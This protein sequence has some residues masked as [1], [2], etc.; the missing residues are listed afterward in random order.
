MPNKPDACKELYELQEQPVTVLIIHFK[1]RSQPISSPMDWL[2]MQYELCQIL[3]IHM[4]QL[5]ILTEA[6]STCKV[7][8]KHN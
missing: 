7:D 4:I 3:N 1:K 2:H 6:F 8:S 5:M